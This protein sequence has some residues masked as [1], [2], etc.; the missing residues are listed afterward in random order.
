MLAYKSHNAIGLEEI[1]QAL[2]E[3]QGEQVERL[4]AAGEDIVY[5]IVK[6]MSALGDKLRR[7][8]SGIHDLRRVVLL[9]VKVLD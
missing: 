9:E 5:N 7:V 2:Q 8:L 6:G 4:G 3:L 1:R